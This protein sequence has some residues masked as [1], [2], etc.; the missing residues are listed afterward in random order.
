MPGIRDT[1]AEADVAIA[2]D[3][4]TGCDELRRQLGLPG[5]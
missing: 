1:S 4:T 3:D 5:Q 2:A